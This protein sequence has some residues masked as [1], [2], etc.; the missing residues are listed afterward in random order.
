VKVEDA[1]DGPV[2]AGRLVLDRFAWIEGHADIWAVFRDATAFRLVVTALAEQYRS[3]AITAVCGIESRGFLLGAPVAVELRAGFVPIRKTAGLLPGAKVRCATDPD[4]RGQSYVLRMQ[5]SALK[6]GD[7]VVLVDD[8]IETGSQV[9]AAAQMIM[10]CGA[11]L[12]GCSVIVDDMSDALRSKMCR[13][14][15][16]LRADELPGE[17]T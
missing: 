3:E 9:R 6:P 5:R 12:V 1:Q 14:S 2:S 13:V 4:Y 7:R 10:E 17:G 15:S 8:W 16:L 11:E